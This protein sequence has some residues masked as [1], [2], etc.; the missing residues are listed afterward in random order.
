[1]DL[2]Q[3]FCRSITEELERYKNAKLQTSK[4]EIF[5]SSYE[6]EMYIVIYEVLVD[7]IDDL[8]E[9]FMLELLE[10]NDGILDRL[11]NKWLLSRDDNFNQVK[12]YIMKEVA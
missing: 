2:K 9:S 3:R 12:N 4:E 6:V 1:M 8:S 11:Y 10:C 5:A 7:Q